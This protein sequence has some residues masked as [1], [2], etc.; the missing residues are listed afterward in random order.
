M[1]KYKKEIKVV[2]VNRPTKEQATN[3]IKALSAFLSNACPPEKKRGAGRPP[4]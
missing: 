1:H 4:P 3:R 2:V